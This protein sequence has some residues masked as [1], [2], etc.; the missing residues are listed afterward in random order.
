MPKKKKE[1]PNDINSTTAGEI[2]E[3]IAT[4]FLWVW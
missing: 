4:D 2:R 3:K 1:T